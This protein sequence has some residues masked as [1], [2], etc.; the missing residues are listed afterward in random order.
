VSIAELAR[1]VA[2]VVGYEGEI[3]FDTS[4]LDGPPR[5]LLTSERLQK[6]GWNPKVSLEQGLATAYAD[7]AGQAA[8]QL[9]A[10]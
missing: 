9:I 7:F 2:S 3:T 8:S 6:L 5:K 10:A 4:R 1:T